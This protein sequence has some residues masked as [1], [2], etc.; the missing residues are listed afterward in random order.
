MQSLVYSNFLNSIKS[1]FTKETYNYH[2]RRFMNQHKDLTLES[3]LRLPVPKIEQ[4]LINYMVQAK[5]KGL[6]AR[7][8]N[9]TL[10]TIKHLCVMNDVRIN[11]RK[12]GKF[13]GEQTSMNQDRAYTYEEIRKLLDVCDLR[14][15]T[16]ILLLA[17]TGM[18]IGALPTLTTHD[19]DVSKHKV[20]VYAGTKD[21]YITFMTPECRQVLESYLDYRVRSGEK[22]TPDSPLIREQ[23]DINDFE[24]IR[25]RCKPITRSTIVNLLHHCIVKAGLKTVN[26]SYSGKERHAVPLAHGFR[27]FFTTQ[28]VNSRINPEIREML[29]GH[30]IGLASAYYKPTEDEMLSEYEKA[31]DA[32]TIDPANR[33]RKK[34]EKLEVEAS[35]L[36][37][38]QAAVAALE[39]KIK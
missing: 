16:I 13:L 18:R 14:M 17:S 30:K 3:F 25:K 35:Q 15:K 5:A 10:S 20:T 4:L 33:L 31:I 32:L 9:G 12:I 38:L 22:I 36:Q 19:L 2:L 27:K 28:L 21:K 34:V 26:H 24:Q 39:K 1:E 29:L 8:I 11:E 7:Y 6:S 37:R 23:F